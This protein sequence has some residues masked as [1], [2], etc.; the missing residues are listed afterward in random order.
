MNS[1]KFGIHLTTT[2]MVVYKR[3]RAVNGDP[4]GE[5]VQWWWH[6]SWRRHTDHSRGVD[7]GELWIQGGSP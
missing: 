4:A 5:Q 6:R 3:R 1:E 2:S 7:I